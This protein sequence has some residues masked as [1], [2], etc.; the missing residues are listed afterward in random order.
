LWLLCWDGGSITGGKWRDTWNR[1]EF[2]TQIYASSAQK[3]NLRKQGSAA[4]SLPPSSAEL[5]AGITA[6][7]IRLH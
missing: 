3:L 7:V 2:T 6:A 4:Y 1:P 5:A